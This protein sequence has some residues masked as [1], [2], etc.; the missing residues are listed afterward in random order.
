MSN[1]YPDGPT[2]ANGY[3][4]PV[5]EWERE[6]Q[7]VSAAT[8]RRCRGTGATDSET[9]VATAP[10]SIS[11]VECSECEGTGQAPVAACKCRKGA[12][13]PDCPRHPKSPFRGTSGRG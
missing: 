5:D 4:S 2:S 7:H 6:R 8:C 3:V 12:W 1:L 11:A 10:E 13:N 9:G